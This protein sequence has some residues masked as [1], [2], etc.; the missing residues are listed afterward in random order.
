MRRREIKL[1]LSAK[2]RTKDNW[3]DL[4]QRDVFQSWN[5]FYRSFL[6]TG[7]MKREG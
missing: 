6:G 2:G 3:P 7:L 4:Y 5:L 1:P